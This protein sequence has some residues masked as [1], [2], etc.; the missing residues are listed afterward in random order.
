MT[1]TDS[2][3]SQSRRETTPLPQ[4]PTLRIARCEEKES[5]EAS[6]RRR[7]DA[8]SPGKTEQGCEGLED[9]RAL[10]PFL[11]VVATISNWGA[12]A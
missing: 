10:T 3:G 2:P 1:G 12:R 4:P 5:A 11:R 6:V 7:A 8:D 9:L